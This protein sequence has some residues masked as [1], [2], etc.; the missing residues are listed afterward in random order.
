MDL[1]TSKKFDAFCIVSSDGDFTRLALRLRAEGRAVFGIGEERKTSAR[2]HNACDRFEY[3]KAATEVP[4]KSSPVAVPKV[5]SPSVKI[6]KT[7]TVTAN[8]AILKAAARLINKAYNQR[9]GKNQQGFATWTGVVSQLDKNGHALAFSDCGAKSW[10]GVLQLLPEIFETTGA[11]NAKRIKPR[12]ASV[13][14][15]V[16]MVG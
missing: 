16:P 4:K 15:V 3:L 11:G 12:A 14:N 6:P 2:L 5:A 10:E 13:T 8:A 9:G 7:K 1:M